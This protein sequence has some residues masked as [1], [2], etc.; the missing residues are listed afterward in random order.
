[1]EFYCQNH[2]ACLHDH[3]CP[4]LPSDPRDSTVPGFRTNI[5]AI[6]RCP[7]GKLNQAIVPRE[8]WGTPAPE[9]WNWKQGM[10]S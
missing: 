5:E 2:E 7:D 1:M 8:R 10:V 6:K 3:K 4:I 9:E